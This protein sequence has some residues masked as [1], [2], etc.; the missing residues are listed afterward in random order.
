MKENQLENIFN[1]DRKTF[2]ALNYSPK[3]KDT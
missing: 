1:E 3:S 2:I